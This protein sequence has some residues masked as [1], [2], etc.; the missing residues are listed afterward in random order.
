MTERIKTVDISH[1]HKNTDTHTSDPSR[2][3][4]IRQRLLESLRDDGFLYITGHNIPADLINTIFTISSAFFSQPADYKSQYAYNPSVNTGY[5]S[6]SR[7]KL[8]PNSTQSDSK[9]AFNICKFIPPHAQLSSFPEEFKLNQDKIEVFAKMV[10]GLCM[11]LLRE[12]AGALGV[13]ED[14]FLERH[15][16]EEPSGDILRFL[17][18]PAIREASNYSISP[19][20]LI[21]AG[22]HSDYGSLTI[23]FQKDIGGL[24]VLLG[25][26]DTNKEQLVW[27]PVPV[28]KDA[29]VV[30]AGDLLEFWTGGLIKSTVHRV[31]GN[32]DSDKGRQSIAYFCHPCDKTMLETIP[33]DLVHAH[34]KQNA[35]NTKGGRTEGGQEFTAGGKA[36]GGGGVISARE[37]L[38]LSPN[39]LKDQQPPMMPDMNTNIHHDTDDETASQFSDVTTTT[40]ATATTTASAAAAALFTCLACHVAFRTADHQREHYR[41]DWHRYNLKRKVAELPPVS[42]ENFALRLKAQQQKLTEDSAKTSFSASCQACSKT[43]STEN[44]YANHLSSKKHKE[45]QAAFDK[46]LKAVSTA[47]SPKRTAPATSTTSGQPSSSSAAVSSSSSSSSTSTTTTEQPT[48]IPWRVK[49]A[50]A[51]TEDELNAL[52]DQK[53]AS[54]VRLQPTDCLFCTQSS[55]SLDENLAHMALHH[56]FFIPDLEYLVDLNG[57]ITYLG[58]KISVGNVCIYCNGK[59]RSFH[60]LESVRKHMIDK[61]H[62]KIAYEDGNEMDVADFYDFSSTWEEMDKLKKDGDEWEDVDGEDVEDGDEVVENDD[63]DNESIGSS[64]GRNVMYLSEDSMHLTLPSG[65]TV[66]HRAYHRP[67]YTTPTNAPPDS[68]VIARLAGRYADMNVQAIHSQFARKALEFEAKKQNRKVETSY[69]DF[70]TR[71]GIKHNK[72]DMNRHFRSQIGFD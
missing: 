41:S 4:E 54:S 37:H 10:H 72:S 21:R 16:Y 66:S 62:C 22:G 46:K 24:E 15:R 5:V 61:G 55:P 12:L 52:I 17:C 11:T 56:S 68:L 59:G 44:G 40:A 63:S 67:R 3:R 38:D 7:E 23:L 50:Q 32:T 36:G 65:R 8:N 29:V 42:Q 26:R 71:V 49:L 70:K 13:E 48:N 69:R 25:D 34:S 57:L 35:K 6:P 64:V 14:Y 9:E 43:Y 28:I 45:A 1:L 20:P 53:I 58:E 19:Q 33:S 39:S 27:T 51:K 31:V 2:R 30:N 47:T 18:Y 60:S